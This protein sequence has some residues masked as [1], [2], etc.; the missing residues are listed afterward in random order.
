MPV[1]FGELGGAGFHC[2]AE[3]LGTGLNL[4]QS[5]ALFLIG[6]LQ[7]CCPFLLEDLDAVGQREGE[8]NGFCGHRKRK[9][10]GVRSEEPT[11]EF[12]SLMR[13]SYAVFCLNTTYIRHIL[14]YK[15]LPLYV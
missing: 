2:Q 5:R 6:M 10:V 3:L 9:K 12:Q 7:R 4:P 8:Q 14:V 11:S 1:G 13:I 15:H